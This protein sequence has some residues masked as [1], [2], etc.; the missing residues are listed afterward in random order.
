[1]RPLSTS[2][3]AS[4]MRTL[5][6]SLRCFGRLTVGD[7]DLDLDTRL[8]ADRCNLLDDLGGTVQI[9]DTLV[10]AHLEAIPGLG[11]LTARRLARRDAQ[12]LRGHADGSEHLQLL[13]L[14]TL[15]QVSAHL[16]QA[17]H[18][19]ARQRDADAVHRRGLLDLLALFLVCHLEVLN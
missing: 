16:L 8:D 14:G 6:S 15:D 19:R 10:D 18:V 1:M 9:D 2:L 3:C 11:A 7:D 4:S 17:L 5:V 12:L 13:L